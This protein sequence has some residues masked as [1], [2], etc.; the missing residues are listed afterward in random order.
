MYLIGLIIVSLAVGHE[1]SQ[2]AGWVT[3]GVGLL[4]GASR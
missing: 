1:F 4:L 2:F 3:F